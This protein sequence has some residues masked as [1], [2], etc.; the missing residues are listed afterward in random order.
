MGVSAAASMYS[1]TYSTKAAATS[2]ADTK[3]L[4]ASAKKAGATPSRHCCFSSGPRVKTSVAKATPAP[5]DCDISPAERCSSAASLVARN[6]SSHA[7]DTLAQR[8][9]LQDDLRRDRVE[10]DCGCIRGG[11][12][13]GLWRRHRLPTRA[14][15]LPLAW[16][17]GWGGGGGLVGPERRGALAGRARTADACEAALVDRTHGASRPGGRD[18]SARHR[19][20]LSGLPRRLRLL[21]GDDLAHLVARLGDG[22][23]LDGRGRARELPAVEAQVEEVQHHEAH[24]RGQQRVAREALR[25]LHDRAEAA[26]GLGHA[27]L[28]PT[29][30]WSR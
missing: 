27:R 22:D 23:A 10:A 18:R 25:E 9:A 30:A 12:C 16:R 8:V 1:G 21:C 26:L 7:L 6:S 14:H 2:C 13:S 17:S 15:G 11:H 24:A 19:G 4:L 29:P 3:P 5:G 20:A 28:R